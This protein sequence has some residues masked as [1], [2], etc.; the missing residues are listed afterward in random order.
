MRSKTKICFILSEEVLRLHV[1]VKTLSLNIASHLEEACDVQIVVTRRTS[2]K[3]FYYLTPKTHFSIFQSGFQETLSA[4]GSPL[5]VLKK[6][7]NS[8]YKKETC[9]NL[10]TNHFQFFIP[11]TADY[12]N[13]FDIVVFTSPWELPQH[14]ELINQ[15]KK[16]KLFAIIHDFIPIQYSF[17][18]IY[19]ESLRDFGY[20]HVQGYAIIKDYFKGVL[21]NSSKTKKECDAYFR[22]C[23]ENITIPPLA[24]EIFYKDSLITPNTTQ[25]TL[26]LANAL[27][28]RKRLEETIPIIGK[29]KVKNLII[30]GRP[31]CHFSYVENFFKR[32]PSNINVTY[33]N[34]IT[35]S[36][37]K[38]VFLESKL[39]LF[40]SDHEGLGIPIIESRLCNTK[41][42]TKP[43]SPMKEL[44]EEEIFF[45]GDPEKDLE[46]VDYHLEAPKAKIDRQNLYRQKKLLLTL[47]E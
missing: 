36:K 20:A 17:H 18:D 11:D 40:P 25:N 14:L 13:S 5:K 21:C 19:N 42:M 27:D 33:Y 47:F 7:K 31:R 4:Q 9:E 12:I 15:V 46:T 1:G 39:L 3:S 2:N 35:P 24:N 34:K 44:N 32:I 23:L 29:A 37:L 8:N 16:E 22:G 43:H 45:S 26:I 30:Y 28:P 10:R 38:H 6:I 41:V